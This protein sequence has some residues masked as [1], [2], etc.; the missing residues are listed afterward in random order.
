MVVGEFPRYSPS[1]CQLS[2]RRTST[3]PGSDLNAKPSDLES[4]IEHSI[5]TRKAVLKRLSGKGLH[6][7]SPVD[8]TRFGQ[9][10]GL[11]GPVE[12][13]AGHNAVQN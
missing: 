9:D 12:V 3:G 11:I 13:D 1:L 5:F 8:V 7:P 2:Y 10:D 4:D 6:T